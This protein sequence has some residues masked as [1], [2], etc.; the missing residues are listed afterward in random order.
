ME[1]F[2]KYGTTRITFE[3]AFADRRT[4]GITV[5]PDR[6]VAVTAPLETSLSNVCAKV[7]KRAAWITKQQ[8]FFLG[9]EP[10]TPPRRFVSGEAHLY[11][12]RQYRLKIMEAEVES[13]KLSGGFF[14]ARTQVQGKESGSKADEARNL[15]HAWYQEKADFHFPR[16]AAP[17]LQRFAR[18]GVTPSDFII[19][20]MHKRWGSC[21]AAG[22]IILNT[23]LIRAPRGCI[24]YVI[25]HE[26]CHLLHHDH[27]AKFQALQAREFPAWEKWKTVLEEKMV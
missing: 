26:L 20:K 8:R 15:L 21:T 25:V 6:R 13:I 18:L 4:L 5:H 14:V 12:G 7:R 10:K 1:H 23:E 27:G 16:I 2:V 22:K 3:L 24:E 19:R 17:Y 9:F 11:L